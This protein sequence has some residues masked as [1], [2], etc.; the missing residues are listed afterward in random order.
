V[1][2]PPPTA[3]TA[4]LLLRPLTLADAPQIQALFPQWEIVKYLAA[5]VP[6]PYPPD[7]A[8]QFLREVALPQIEHGEGWHWSLRLLDDPE[9]IIGSIGLLKNEEENRGFWLDPRHQ[10]RGLMSEACIWATDFWFDVLGFERLRVPKASANLA[11][12]RISEKQGMH[13]VSVGEKDYVCGRLKS[14]I[15]EIT[16]EEWRAWKAAHALPTAARE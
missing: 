12:R 14:E 13:L 3:R 4:C 15:W 6:W 8:E 16:A 9:R 2:C 10:G 7:G 5:R 1:T 11:S